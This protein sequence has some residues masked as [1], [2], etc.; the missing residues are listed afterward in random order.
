MYYLNLFAAIVKGD[1]VEAQAI[2]NQ[3]LSKSAITAHVAVATGEIVNLE[4][5]VETSEE[6]LKLAL[7]NNGQ[8][9]ED[10]G[11]Y[12]EGLL[13]AQNNVT[14]AKKALTKKKA[15]IKFLEEQ[16]ALVNKGGDASTKAGSAPAK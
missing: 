6:K 5:A 4:T 9:I 7:A 2:K 3:R 8:L 15:G 14:N 11:R 1:N 16:L 10:N 12:V 13:A